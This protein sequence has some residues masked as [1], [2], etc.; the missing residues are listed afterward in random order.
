MVNGRL[1]LVFF[2]D[3]PR[4]AWW[5][6]ALR[7]GFR[8]VWAASWY[9]DQA[10]WV[11]FNPAIDGTTI[12]L[13]TADEWPVK[14]ASL[15]EHSS[16]ALRMASRRDRLRTST[17]PWCVGAIKALLGIHVFALTPYRLHLA[18]LA[19]GAEIVHRQIP[20]VAAKPEAAAPSAV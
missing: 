3:T 20:C 4:R 17:L 12:M 6:N 11:Y 14:L 1:W 19:C 16:V 8:H 2:G 7:P 15:L 13:F 18:L 10:R 5:A 9:A